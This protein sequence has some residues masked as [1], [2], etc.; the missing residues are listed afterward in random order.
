MRDGKFQEMLDSVPEEYHGD[1]LDYAAEIEQTIERVKAD[2]ALAFEG[3]PK[4]DRKEFAMW[5][6]KY[7][8]EIAP[9]LFAK[10]DDKPLE[11]LIF[12]KEF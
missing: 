4:G 2:V 5:T 1:I 8:R 11:P 10:M 3:A 9:Y 6:N 12:K 7:H